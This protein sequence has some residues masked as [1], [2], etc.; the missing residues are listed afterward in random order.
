MA[1]MTATETTVRRILRARP[2]VRAGALTAGA[3][4]LT[5]GAGALTAGKAPVPS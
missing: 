3:G 5:A 2:G 4:A 1:A